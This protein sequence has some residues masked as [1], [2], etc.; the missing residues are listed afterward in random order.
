MQYQQLTDK[1][2]ASDILTGIKYMSQ[3]YM[4]AIMEAQ[5]QNL[6]QTF[7]DYHDQCLNDQY[8]LFQLM[9]QNGWY[10]VPM[11]LDESRQNI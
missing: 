6:R 2:I 3:G 5:D 1:D 9:Q 11:I 10:K 7:K 8:R 4:H